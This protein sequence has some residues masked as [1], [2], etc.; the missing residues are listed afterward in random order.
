MKQAPVRLLRLP[1]FR[2]RFG[3]RLC[4]FVLN[5]VLLSDV[6]FVVVG[7]RL[8]SRFR[9]SSRWYI[10]MSSLPLVQLSQPRRSDIS[11]VGRV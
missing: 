11:V 6:V 9:A 10:F 7:R 2:V 1:R 8:C 3:R 5:V 4:L